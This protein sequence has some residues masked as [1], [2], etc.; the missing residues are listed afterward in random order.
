[1]SLDIVWTPLHRLLAFMN[2]DWA[3]VS[4]ATKV[5][6]CFYD[7]HW[8]SNAHSI[9]CE[10]YP[11]NVKMISFCV[12][13]VKVFHQTRRFN[14]RASKNLNTY[15]DDYF[16]HLT[17][18]WCHRWNVFVILFS[19]RIPLLLQHSPWSLLMKSLL[20]LNVPRGVNLDTE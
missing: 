2:T 14:S 5:D 13:F 10:H 8:K 15:L 16:P 7:I 11:V 12:I 17:R 20:K 19:D 6:K 18:W 4:W 9:L 1:M 3:W